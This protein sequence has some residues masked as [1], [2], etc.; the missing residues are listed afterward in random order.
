M[1]KMVL[2]QHFTGGNKYREVINGHE[3]IKDKE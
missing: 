3:R 2:A 1:K